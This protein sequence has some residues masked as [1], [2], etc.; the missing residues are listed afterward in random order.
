MTILFSS[1][2][3]NIPPFQGHIVHAYVCRYAQWRSP[4]N[5]RRLIQV[6][7]IITGI[8]LHMLR[9]GRGFL[10]LTLEGAE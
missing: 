7:V 6:G 1:L 2:Q 9:R 10:S 8:I 4:N 3:K 5:T